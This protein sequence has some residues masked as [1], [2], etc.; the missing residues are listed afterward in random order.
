LPPPAAIT[1]VPPPPSIV[2]APAPPV[3]VFAA[4]VPVIEI[5]CTA[6]R[7]LASTFS[8]FVTLTESP[9][10]WSALARFTV[11]AVLSCSVLLPLPPSIETSEPR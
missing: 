7:P 4:A 9:E 1:S 3:I 10:V 8:K 2:S 6:V 5:P 11:A